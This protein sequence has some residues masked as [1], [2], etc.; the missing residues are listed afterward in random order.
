MHTRKSWVKDSTVMEAAARMKESLE[1]QTVNVG[2]FLTALEA[3]RRLELPV[4]G[5]HAQGSRVKFERID[6]DDSCASALG[7]CSPARARLVSHPK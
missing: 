6:H 4:R 2:A 1:S 3:L 5:T 7:L